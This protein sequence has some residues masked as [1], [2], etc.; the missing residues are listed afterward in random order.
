ML[1]KCCPRNILCK[2]AAVT[3]DVMNTKKSIEIQCNLSKEMTDMTL[4][5]NQTETPILPSAVDEE[6]L[7][8]LSC[9]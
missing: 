1:R 2:R 7:F 9:L 5:E 3:Y 8:S 6:S 4:E